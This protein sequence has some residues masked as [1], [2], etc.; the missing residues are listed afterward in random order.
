MS[1]KKGALQNFAKFTG[2]LY[3]QGPATLFKVKLRHRLFFVN[4]AKYL[5]FFF[6]RTPLVTASMITA[7]TEF[8]KSLIIIFGDTKFYRTFNTVH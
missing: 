6:D 2:K 1:Y 4:F 8:S 3:S 5:R 7:F